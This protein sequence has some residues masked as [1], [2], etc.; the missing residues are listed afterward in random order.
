MQHDDRAGR[1]GVQGIQHSLE[2]QA[3][4]RRVVVGVG[5]H[6]E[7]GALK[8]RAVVLPARIADPDLRRRGD[9]LEEVR[10]DLE[11]A[12]AAER[13]DGDDPVFGARDAGCAKH[14]FLNCLVVDGEA[15]DRQVAAG[16]RGLGKLLLRGTHAVEHGQLAGIV[17]IHAD[18]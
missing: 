3:V 7:A 16:C 8:Q 17:A 2:I 12:C 9:A 13:L 15:I 1:H 11:A 5:V 18:A 10:A 14:Q 4:R 6:G